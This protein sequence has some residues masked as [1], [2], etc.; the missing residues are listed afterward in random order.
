[1]GQPCGPQCLFTRGTNTKRGATTMTTSLQLEAS[2]TEIMDTVVA[3][4][5]KATE[6]EKDTPLFRR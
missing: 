2:H 3:T 5:E 4:V 6:T 1:M